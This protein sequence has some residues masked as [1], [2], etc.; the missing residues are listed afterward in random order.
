MLSLQIDGEGAYPGENMLL[1][2]VFT[3]GSVRNL[4]GFWEATGSRVEISAATDDL[5]R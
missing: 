3:E 5:L 4:D 2:L 1:D